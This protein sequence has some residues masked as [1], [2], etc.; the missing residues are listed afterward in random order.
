MDEERYSSQEYKKFYNLEKKEPRDIYYRDYCRIIHSPSFRRLQCKCQ[1]FPIGE[2]DFFRNRLTHSLE[3]SQIGKGIVFL[4]N[5]KL[6]EIGKNDEIKLQIVEIAGLSHDLGHPPFGHQGEKALDDCMIEYGGFEGNA[7]TLRIL[8]KLEKKEK[9]EGSESSGIKD[10][11][12]NRYGLN[13]TYRSL[14]SI[15]KYDKKIPFERNKKFSKE[16]FIRHFKLILNKRLKEENCLQNKIDEEIEI[17]INSENIKNI[18]EELYKNKVIVDD[19][20]CEN[21]LDKLE[22]TKFDKNIEKYRLDVIKSLTKWNDEVGLQKGY[23]ESEEEIVKKIKK[24]VIGNENQEDFKTIECQ[25]MDIADDIAYSTYDFEDGLK[26][27][28]ISIWD[29]ISPRKEVLKYIRKE[30]NKCKKLEKDDYTEKD[31]ADIF[32]KIFNEPLNLDAFKEAYQEYKDEKL[33]FLLSVNVFY[34]LIKEFED[35]GYERVRLTSSLIARFIYGVEI[36]SSNISPLM[37]IELNKEI[38]EEV[39][40]LKNFTYICLISSNLLKIPE[41]RGYEI[42]QNIFE[43][44]QG[45]E[46]YKLLP[47]DYRELY[48]KLEC[49]KDKKRLIC[50]FIAGMTDR[51]VLEFYGRLKSENPQ[52]IFK[53]IF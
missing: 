2:S 48:L 10:G 49:E 19:L 29:C 42:V 24:N 12:D 5:Q 27:K 52:S 7:Q 44:L 35:N 33:D 36:V 14:A 8:T 23:Y 45:S 17:A 51:Y 30:L 46:G 18:I 28:F 25:I 20:L 43:V 6:K 50:D 11:E 38:R 4:I 9:I 40:V 22:H 13:L 41:Y 21:C 15:L 37:Q 1:L 3:V 39:E 32:R 26:G 16:V 34:D 47:D 31:V 53:P